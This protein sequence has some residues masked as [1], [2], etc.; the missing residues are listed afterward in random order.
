MK[1]FLKSL[2]SIFHT[3]KYS[4]SLGRSCK[5]H[6][7]L[8]YPSPRFAWSVA[9]GIR[10]K[11][12]PRLR[13]K[14]VIKRDLKDFNIDHSDWLNLSLDRPNWRQALRNG[15]SHDSDTNL[16]KLRAKRSILNNNNKKKQDEIFKCRA[17]SFMIDA[18][19]SS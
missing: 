15:R 10:C 9:N 19:Q 14:D 2:A 12:R 4:S 7:I 17:L 5:P 16:E 11:G 18:C 3:E 6:A 13:F 8:S 1:M